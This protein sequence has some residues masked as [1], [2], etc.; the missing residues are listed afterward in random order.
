MRTVKNSLLF[1]SVL[2]TFAYGSVTA[3][4][5]HE[6]WVLDKEK[7]TIEGSMSEWLVGME[8]VVTIAGDNLKLEFTYQ[9]KDNNFT[10]VIEVT[11][12]AEAK[13]RNIMG[14]MGQGKATSQAQHDDSQQNVTM[15]TD[16]TIEGNNGTSKFS[17]DDLYSRS[18]DWE[19]LILKRKT[20]SK[21]GISNSTLIFKK[22]V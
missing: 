13:T 15:H 18:E 6:S 1:L 17:T 8:L 14:R 9:T 11:F 2:C 16:W 3:Q 4:E 19:N 12:G 20:E 7:S 10:D 21:S 5:L 22:N